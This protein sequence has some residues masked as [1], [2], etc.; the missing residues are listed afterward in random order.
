MR[1]YGREREIGILRETEERSRSESRFTVVLGRRRIGKTSTIRKALEH[2]KIVY[3]YISRMKEPLFCRRMQDIAEDAGIEFTGSVSTVREFLRA[4]MIHS[5]GEPITLV[6]D[7][8][9]EL[10]HV[11]P[12]VFS[13]IQEI[14]DMYKD[15]SRINLVVAGSM[16]SMMVRIFENE[17]QPL[18]GR[19]T[20]KLELRPLPI[21]T[22]KEIMRDHEPSY[23]NRSLL[24][25]YMLSGGVPPY[26]AALMD[27]KAFDT[28][29]M[30]ETAL[31]PG[32]IF[33][34]DGT[35]L[36]AE[37]FGRDKGTYTSILILIAEGRNTRSE[38]EGILGTGVGPYL[39]RLEN[40]YGMIRRTVPIVGRNEKISRWEISDQYLRFFYRYIRPNEDLVETDRT[41]L[42]IKMV[43]KDLESYEGRVLK[44]YL[45]RRIA[46]EEDFTAVGRYWNRKGDAEV[47]IVAIDLIGRRAMLAEVK[48]NPSK[49]DMGKLRRTGETVPGLDGYEVSYRGLSMDDM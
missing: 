2:T 29:S 13:D 24:T 26:V 11:G 17:K 37:E 16:H 1:F 19:A 14:W 9:Q 34:R 35:D 15:E 49:I 20:G 36:M 23:D 43:E 32:S 33:L 8:F 45:R 25:L 48:R 39:Q 46:E 28:R 42:L 4:V 18:F 10:D 41:D 3:V 7:E 38:M 40:E 47:D 5:R 30:I 6:L 44:E 31:S 12:S 27:A 22:L 21:N